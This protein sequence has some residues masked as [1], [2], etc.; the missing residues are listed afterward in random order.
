VG[1]DCGVRDGSWLPNFCAYNVYHTQYTYAFWEAAYVS[2]NRAQ[3]C[4]TVG[5]ED[6]FRWQKQRMHYFLWAAGVHT[7]YIAYGLAVAADALG[8]HDSRMASYY[9]YEV[10]FRM[11]GQC[12]FC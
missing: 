2:A 11:E 12:G 7:E 4:A 1:P 9:L 3:S 5:N 8:S 10:A 6:C